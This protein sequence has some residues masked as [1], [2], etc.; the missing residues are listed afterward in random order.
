MR[1]LGSL[2]LRAQGV[3]S[4]IGGGLRSGSSGMAVQ[5][6][7]RIKYVAQRVHSVAACFPLRALTIL[8]KASLTP[9]RSAHL[10]KEKRFIRDHRTSSLFRS[11]SSFILSFS[12]LLPKINV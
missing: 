7:S 2:L 9:T 5:I 11:L 8:Q 6:D 1:A 3:P 12:P 4:G 10:R